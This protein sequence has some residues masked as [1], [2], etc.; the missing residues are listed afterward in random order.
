MGL[1]K[2]GGLVGVHKD[3]LQGLDED[4]GEGG[5]GEEGGGVVGVLGGGY[6]AF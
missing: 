3:V 5:G 2:G 6:K 1:L 4:Q